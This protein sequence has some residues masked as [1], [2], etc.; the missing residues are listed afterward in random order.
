M[1]QTPRMLQAPRMLWTFQVIPQSNPDP[2]GC[3]S[4]LEYSD[5]LK[6]SIPPGCSVLFCPVLSCPSPPDTAS[7]SGPSWDPSRTQ[8]P[9]LGLPPP[10][11]A[12]YTDSSIHD[13]L[14]TSWVRTGCYLYAS[15]LSPW[16]HPRLSQ[17]SHSVRPS[18]SGVLY[19]RPH[20][21]PTLSPLPAWSQEDVAPGCSI[22]P[23]GC[24]CPW[25]AGVPWAGVKCPRG[26][27]PGWP[28]AEGPQ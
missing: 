22:V 18:V 13:T 9:A 11:A 4:P 1:F 24:R 3:P 25:G 2:L 8:F 23:T 5:P 21:V 6:C 14:A 17:P 16:L 10:G 20:P 15:F 19:I 26:T 12:P 7:G 28:L 27:P